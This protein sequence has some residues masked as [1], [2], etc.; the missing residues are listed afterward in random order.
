MKNWI[1]NKIAFI[2]EQIPFTVLR[3][4]TKYPPVLPFY[5][6]VSNTPLQHIDSYPVRTEKQ[7]EKE[8]DFLLRHFKAVDLETII[9]KPGY[10]YMHLSFDDGLK[11]CYTVIAPI[12]LKKGIPATFFVNPGFVD[13]QKIFHRFKKTLLKRDGIL[14]NNSRVYSI[15]DNE[16]LNHLAEQN[17]VS[18]QK[19]LD[20]FQPYLSYDEIAYLHEKGFLIGAHSMDHPEFGLLSLND[21]LNQIQQSIS[22]VNSHFN[23]ALKVFSFPFTD[24]GVSKELFEMMHDKKIVDYT[25]GTAGLKNDNI[26]FHFQRIHIERTQNWS[27]KKTL[28]F[29]YF[30]YFVRSVFGK[31]VVTH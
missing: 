16:E 10:N 13:N 4:R 31:N 21:Q 7:F 26:P 28:H 12:L 27:V 8:L 19:Y 5:H 23:P 1:L 9:Q 11:E 14:P 17:N 20:D 18:F 30:Y 24:H 22:W 29:E 3:G 6:T 15:A 2:A 25:F